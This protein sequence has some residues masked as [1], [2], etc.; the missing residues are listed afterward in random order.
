MTETTGNSQPKTFRE[1]WKSFEQKTKKYIPGFF[2]GM[3]V[4]FLAISVLWSIFG[5]TDKA[6]QNLLLAGLMLGCAVAIPY[7]DRQKESKSSDQNS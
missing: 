5:S 4:L 6:I 3:S 7:L 2:L 1:K